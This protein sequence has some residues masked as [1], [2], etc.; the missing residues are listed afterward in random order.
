MIM[1]LLRMLFTILESDDGGDGEDDD[2]DIDEIPS[3]DVD[4]GSCGWWLGVT[5]WTKFDEFS[6]NFQTASDPPPYFR[7]KMLRFCP[8][9]RCP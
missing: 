9:N 4:V 6:E 8:G 3:N 5:I 1:I 2:H 7:K